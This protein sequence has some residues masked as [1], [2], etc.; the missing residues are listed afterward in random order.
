MK[1][2]VLVSIF[3]LI[4]CSSNTDSKK[5]SDGS[6]SDS[7]ITNSCDCVD[8]DID[9]TGVHYLNDSLYTGICVSYFVNTK[10]KYI[11]KSILKGKLHGKVVYYDKSGEVLLQELYENG[12]QKRSGETD[13]SLTCDC[14][15]LEVHPN[16]DPIVPSQYWLDDMPF[17]GKCEKY[18]PD[19]QQLSLEVN[20]KNGYQDGYTIYYNRDGSTILMERYTSGILVSTVN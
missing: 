7:D 19:S 13:K 14:A 17:S 8:L 16:T 1:F 18:Y 5:T 20:Y 4:S 3:I 12:K 11:E 10:S 15:E 9:S 2:L 6:I